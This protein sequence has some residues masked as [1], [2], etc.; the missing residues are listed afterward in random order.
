TVTGVRFPTVTGVR[1]LTVLILGLERQDGDKVVGDIFDDR[2]QGEDL[3]R[4]RGFLGHLMGGLGSLGGG[5]V[6]LVG[7]DR[8]DG[9]T[10]HEQA[11]R[12]HGQHPLLGGHP[13]P[14]F[15]SCCVLTE[16]KW[17]RGGPHGPRW[18]WRPANRGG[19]RHPRAR[20]RVHRRRPPPHRARRVHRR[21]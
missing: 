8:A 14:F 21:P 16:G 10:G 4:L 7:E 2:G 12:R 11:R 5:L 6:H 15:Y 17:H 9:E 18:R 13:T 20:R 3:H 1:I 19:S